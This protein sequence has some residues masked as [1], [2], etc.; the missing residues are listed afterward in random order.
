MATLRFTAG[1]QAV[2]QVS[3]VT[4]AGTWVAGETVTIQIADKFVT[5]T[6]VSGSEDVTSIADALV[7][8]CNAS[9]DGEFQ[10]VNTW[11]NVAGVITMTGNAGVPITITS[12]ETS[13]SGTAVTATTTTAT[14]PS[15]WDNIDNWDTGAVPTTNDSVYV[16]DP[17]YA[18]KYG[19]PS[20]LTLTKL[21]VYRGQLGLPIEN[22]LGYNEYRTARPG[23]T[24]T[25]VVIGQR[26]GIGPS[27]CRLDLEAAAAVVLVSGTGQPPN[28]EYAVDLLLNNAAAEVA[29][30]SGTVA[31]APAGTETSTVGTVR[32]GAETRILVGE[33]V[34]LTSAVN[35]GAMRLRSSATN[36]T[37]EGGTVT[38]L[39]DITVTNLNVYG[40]ECDHQSSGTT[41]TTIVEN[42]ALNLDNDLR[43]KTFTNI[44]LN[45][46]GSMLHT[47]Q[48]ATFTNGITQGANTNQLTAV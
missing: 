29:A 16:D 17:D 40:G 15:H 3:T 36:V 42:A 46:G 20:G 10:D 23:I 30:T 28:S 38:L 25:D 22:V 21:V 18:I 24:C 27:V 8:L 7:L 12:S 32:G 19:L 31:I 2:A 41:T 14:G 43:T 26:S 6:V 33:G 13:T 4:I 44:T 5:H 9:T 48:N 1:A 35:A 11:A 39:D 47:Y 37:N 45:Q 34:T